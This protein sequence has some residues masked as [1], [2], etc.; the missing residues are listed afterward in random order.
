M[1][2]EASLTVIESPGMEWK[3]CSQGAGRELAFRLRLREV[4][5]ICRQAGRK[6]RWREEQARNPNLD[7]EFCVFVAESQATKTPRHK[8]R[9]TNV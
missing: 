8:G 4:D 7:T 5:R 9:A 3:V 1:S 2:D 6:A